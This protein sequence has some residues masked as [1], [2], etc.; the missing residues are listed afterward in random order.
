[1]P[2]EIATFDNLVMVAAS[3]ALVIAARS[4]WRIGRLEGAALLAGYIAYVA[5]IWP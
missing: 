2:R 1:V 5:I 3:L 4:G